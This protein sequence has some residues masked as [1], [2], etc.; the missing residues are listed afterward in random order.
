M[1]AYG[2]INESTAEIGWLDF[3]LFVN[4]CEII[5][6]HIVFLL[7][8]QCIK[9]AV[10]WDSPQKPGHL[11]LRKLGLV[12]FIAKIR[13]FFIIVFF[14]ALTL[15][16]V[17][18]LLDLV[19]L[20]LFI[21]GILL[22]AKWMFQPML[23]TFFRSLIRTLNWQF[24]LISSDWFWCVF[25]HHLSWPSWTVLIKRRAFYPA[26]LPIERWSVI[27]LCLLAWWLQKAVSSLLNCDFG[28]CIRV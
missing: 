20:K 3:F 11:V 23:N 2:N 10:T 1:L 24:Q 5:G 19:F 13:V 6:N 8:A 16:L 27:W 4:C 25:S 12:I 14:Q 22:I 17:L 28:V 9:I 26:L 21:C 15:E 18:P 7:G